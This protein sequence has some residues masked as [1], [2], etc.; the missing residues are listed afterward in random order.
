M[1][2]A[3]IPEKLILV[4]LCF[5]F[6]RSPQIQ[7]QGNDRAAPVSLPSLLL[8]LERKTIRENDKIIADIWISNPSTVDLTDL[9]LSVSGRFWSMDCGN[10]TATRLP[11]KGMLHQQLCL[12]TGPDIEIGDFMASAVLQY[13]FEMGKQKGTSF[14]ASEVPISAKLLGTDS[15]AGIPLE[16]AGFIVPGLA[17]WLVLRMSGV[18]WGI[19]SGLG[20]QLIY[21]LLVSLALIYASTA[22]KLLKVDGGIGFQK[23]LHLALIGV[24][25]GVVVSS[26]DFLIR[27]IF[28]A[29]QSAKTPMP[30]DEA[31]ATLLKL[32]RRHARKANP[33]AR[34]RLRTNMNEEF[35][36]SLGLK[37]PTFTVLIGWFQFE[38]KG[39]TEEKLKNLQSLVEKKQ[40]EAAIDFANENKIPIN[41]RNSIQKST[42]GG[43]E[44]STGL[45]IMRWPSRDVSDFQIVSQTLRGEPLITH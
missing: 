18:P 42:D 5:A 34:I 22:L 23:L 39:L 9:K 35:R 7:A 8:T 25:V 14:V 38:T 43:D 20:D 16:L 32:I 24:A 19:A 10:F 33:E 41:L 27:W 2:R 40:F 31:E 37:T 11:A 1:S 3:R 17:F 44:A 6:A 30:D 13:S 29:K 12:K 26:I 4:L 45:T 21:S 36:G 15:I 28:R